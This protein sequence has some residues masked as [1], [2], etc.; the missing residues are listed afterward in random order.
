MRTEVTSQEHF[1]ERYTQK[2]YLIREIEQ[3]LHQ[4]ER[5]GINIGVQEGLFLQTLCT[6]RHVEKV[7]EIGTQYG[8]SASWMAFG[9]GE[10]GTLYTFEKD[11]ICIEN[12]KITFAHPDFVKTGC[13]VQLLEGDALQNLKS[14]E[15]KGPFDLIFIDANKNSYYEYLQWSKENLKA[16]GLIVADNIYLFG[17]LLE[18]KPPEN[19]P[20]KMWK[21][22]DRFVKDL[23]S[24]SSFSVSI[25]PTSEGLLLASKK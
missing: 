21:T 12:A 14:V 1:I 16:G 3:R 20:E 22:M 23:F 13:Q 17:T 6:Q 25:V 11:P 2:P 24:D 4:G 10:R 19:I 9:L 18:E 8:C 5:L 7:V 15:L